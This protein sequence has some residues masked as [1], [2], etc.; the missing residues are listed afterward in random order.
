MLAVLRLSQALARLRF[1]ERVSI[2]DV[3]EALRL[4]EASKES[5]LDDSGRDRDIDRSI[6]STIYRQIRDMAIGR[7]DTIGKSR[8]G[9]A[10]MMIGEDGDASGEEISMVDIRNRC[11]AKGFTESD[12]MNTILEVRK[13][14]SQLF[15]KELSSFSQYEALDIWTRVA[16]NTKLRFTG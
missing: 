9:E 2:E 12:I 15:C 11:I 4:M 7:A 14:F 8:R 10:D 13:T 1:A 16:N 6:T 5:L 3:D